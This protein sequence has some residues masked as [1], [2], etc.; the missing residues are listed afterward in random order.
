M[1]VPE[2]PPSRLTLVNGTGDPLAV[3]V[4]VSE[5]PLFCSAIGADEAPAVIAT[6]FSP[7][8]GGSAPERYVRATRLGDVASQESWE[9]ET[10]ARCSALRIWIGA[11]HDG[12]DLIAR[13]NARLTIVPGSGPGTYTIQG[14]DEVHSVPPPFCPTM[15][16][17]PEHIPLTTLWSH[18]KQT[19]G[20]GEPTGPVCLLGDALVRPT[21]L[22]LWKSADE[23]TDVAPG[24]T[25][26]SV[27]ACS[28]CREEY[29]LLGGIRLLVPPSNWRIDRRMSDAEEH[30]FFDAA[31][32]QGNGLGGFGGAVAPPP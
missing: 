10:E 4:R 27:P 12:H 30:V 26:R 8:D 14:A 15:M 7:A 31:L 6:L 18:T 28:N 16:Q 22:Q 3:S 24:T 1:R 21:T 11:E 13:T 32:V 29:T 17:G 25:V 20:L 2:P 19:L 5:R 23:M 9:F